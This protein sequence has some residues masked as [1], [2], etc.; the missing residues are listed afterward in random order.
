[1]VRCPAVRDPVFLR[2]STTAIPQSFESLD[3]ARYSLVV[4]SMDM[5]DSLRLTLRAKMA[6]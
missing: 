3:A 4:V 1:M 6:L 5:Q 2:F